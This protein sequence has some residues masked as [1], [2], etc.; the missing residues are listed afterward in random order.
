MK[1]LLK[2]LYNDKYIDNVETYDFDKFY[3]F[4]DKDNHI[5]GIAK[6]IISENELQLILSQTELLGKE[7]GYKKHQKLMDFLFG[8]STEMIEQKQ[9]KYYLLKCMHYKDEETITE[10]DQLLFELFH[11]SAYFIKT[12]NIYI[13]IVS[14]NTDIEFQDSL[15][16]IESD[17]FIPIIGFES[18]LYDV[19]AKLPAYFQFDFNTFTTYTKTNQLIIHK[20][21]L[22]LDSILFNVDEKIRALIKNYILKDF[23]HDTEMLNVIKMYYK[24]NFNLTLAAKNCYMHRNT[25]INKIDK[26]INET[27]F[28][29]RDYADAYLVYLALVL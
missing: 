25:F 28:N 3:Y 4:I 13:I 8:K 26:F 23:I 14:D 5:F 12:K 15:K 9:I 22:I 2:K 20:N 1:E 7:L 21:D 16:S 27:H 11:D 6:D 24:T 18:D 19:N 10:L 29:I 17:F